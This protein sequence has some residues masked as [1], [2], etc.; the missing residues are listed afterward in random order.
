M[1]EKGRRQVRNQISHG[2]F[3]ASFAQVVSLLT[4]SLQL[5]VKF[6]MAMSPIIWLAGMIKVLHYAHSNLLVLTASWIEV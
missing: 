5:T 1:G 3:E 4:I 6:Y 2:S